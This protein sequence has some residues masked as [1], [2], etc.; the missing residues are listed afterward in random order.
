MR[1][2]ETSCCGL[3]YDPSF[4]DILKTSAGPDGLGSPTLKLPS[5]S[6]RES[7]SVLSAIL[8]NKAEYSGTT[9]SRHLRTSVPDSVSL[10][11]HS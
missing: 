3:I 8:V 4:K 2:P 11:R 5:D 6:E 7:S 1:S 9:D 10:A